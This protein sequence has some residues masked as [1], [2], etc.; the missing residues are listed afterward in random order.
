MRTKTITFW[1]DPA[2]SPIRTCVEH[3][4]PVLIFTECPFPRSRPA[5]A[6]E[7]VRAQ[8]SACECHV[9]DDSCR[10]RAR[11]DEP[12]ANPSHLVLSDI[13]SLQCNFPDQCGA[14]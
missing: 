13:S 2:L 8:L 5:N 12:D 11:C 6:L 1:W 4:R 14:F 9:T 3:W 10:V 7:W